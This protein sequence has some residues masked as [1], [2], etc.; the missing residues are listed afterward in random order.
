MNFMSFP[1]G[2]LYFLVYEN[3][4]YYF[5][6]KIAQKTHPTICHLI[7]GSLGECASIILRNPFEVIKQQMQLGL[8]G[9][10]RDTVRH[11]YQLRGFAGRSILTKASTADS[12]VLFGERHLSLLL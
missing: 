1:S 5:E 8:D 6:K 12:G 4:K 2:W 3:F 9:K 7:A 11:I 10:V